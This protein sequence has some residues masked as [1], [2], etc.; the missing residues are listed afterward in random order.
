MKV[1]KK[2]LF[3][4]VALA[5]FICPMQV[6]A[7]SQKDVKQIRAQTVGFLRACKKYNR[8]KAMSYVDMKANYQKFYYIKDNTWNKYIKQ[9]K[10]HDRFR[11]ISINVKGNEATVKIE[12]YTDSLYDVFAYCLHDELVH[13]GKWDNKRFHKEVT[14]TLKYFA[15]HPSDEEQS[16][17]DYKLKFKKIRGKWMISKINYDF[18]FLYDSGAT[19]ALRDF[20]KNPFKFLFL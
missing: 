18:M 10:K 8:D 1:L 2:Y 3:L 16:A 13:K 15:K 19:S 4:I 11:I 5:L 6:H 12:Q 14:K 7:S 9:I 20:T 17:F